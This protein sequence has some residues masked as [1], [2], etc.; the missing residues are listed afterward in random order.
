MLCST[1]L[2]VTVSMGTRECGR[3]SRLGPQ[4]GPDAK[5]SCH[6]ISTFQGLDISEEAER[7]ATWF[8]DF[9]LI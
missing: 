9:V 3:V 8:I 7:T 5:T 6:V 2:H 1:A 4:P